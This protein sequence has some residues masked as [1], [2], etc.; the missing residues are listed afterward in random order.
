MQK[1]YTMGRRHTKPNSLFNFLEIKEGVLFYLAWNLL[2]KNQI[3]NSPLIRQ[4]IILSN[5]ATIT[6]HKFGK[7][8]FCRARRR[9]NYIFSSYFCMWFECFEQTKPNSLSLISILCNKTR[10]IVLP[11]GILRSGMG[12]PSAIPS[13]S[14]I[15]T[16]LGLRSLNLLSVPFPVAASSCASASASASDSARASPTKRSKACK[17]KRNNFAQLRME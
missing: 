6:L 1:Y 16:G 9:I 2:N 12:R 8:Y 13:G 11:C 7:S 3:V 4:N 14:E 10:G 15:E 5:H 17:R